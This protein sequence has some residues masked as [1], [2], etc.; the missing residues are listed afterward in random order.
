[1]IFDVTYSLVSAAEP[2]LML[3]PIRSAKQHRPIRQCMHWRY[4]A[5]FEA[6]MHLRRL[7]SCFLVSD[8]AVTTPNEDDI[9]S[10]N[11]AP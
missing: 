3:L 7:G 5:P 11:S 6:T 9:L 1:M 4:Y 8:S 2:F 10:G